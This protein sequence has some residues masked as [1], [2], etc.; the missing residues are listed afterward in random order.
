MIHGD[1][2]TLVDVSGGEATARA[3]PGAQL[4]VVEGMGHDL[5][6]QLYDRMID[7]ILANIEAADKATRRRR[8]RI[9]SGPLEGLRV[10]ELAGIG[11]CPFAGM[12][13]ADLGADVLRVERPSAVPDNDAAGTIVGP[14]RTR[15]AFDRGR[16]QAR[17][18]RGVA[19]GARA[20]GRTSCSRDS[21]PASWSVSASGRTPV[22][23][24]TP[25]WSTA[26]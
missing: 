17:R 20:N 1:S 19:P 21:D 10:V 18:R 4:L 13:L 12:V 24:V 2:D 6:P 9:V 22:G 11:P 25:A 23:H 3:I 8:N 14:A 15:Q 7:A 16:P 5:P 26:G